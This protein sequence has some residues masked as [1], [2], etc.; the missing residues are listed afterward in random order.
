MSDE[1][2]T[3]TVETDGEK[4][5]RVPDNPIKL[6]E[7]REELEADNTKIRERIARAQDQL[8]TNTARLSKINDR[9]T[10]FENSGGGDMRKAAA[11]FVA[12]EEAKVVETQKR[13]AEIRA[14]FGF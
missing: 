1:T 4:I 12:Q 9:L 6:L 7:L 11:D 3:A 8:A 13:M 5:I 14:K 10:K 2:N